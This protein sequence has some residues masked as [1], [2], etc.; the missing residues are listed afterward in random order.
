MIP[1]D[2]LIAL[3]IGVLFTKIGEYFYHK[4]HIIEADISLTLK[5]TQ[6]YGVNLYITFNDALKLS[7]RLRLRL[8]LHL[9]DGE[10][11][12]INVDDTY[13]TIRDRYE[14]LKRDGL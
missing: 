1:F 3:F 9:M 6:G 8:H 5:I 10:I 13:D 2:Y 4:A 12:T 14:K 7:Q 11:L